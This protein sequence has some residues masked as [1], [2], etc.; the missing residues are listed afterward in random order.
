MTELA[1]YDLAVE[2]TSFYALQH[3]AWLVGHVL[4][5]NGKHVARV[6]LMRL[7]EQ[8]ES[9]LAVTEESLAWLIFDY[10]CLACMGEARHS[11]SASNGYLTSFDWTRNSSR[12]S[13]AA[14]VVGNYDPYEFLPKLIDLFDIPKWESSYGGRKWGELA[15]TALRFLDKQW[16]AAVLIDHCVDL[17]HNG[18]LCFNKGF[19]LDCSF[20]Q[21]QL[22]ALLDDKASKKPLSEWHG[23]TKMG[24]TVLWLIHALQRHGLIKPVRGVPVEWCEICGECHRNFEIPLVCRFL[25]DVPPLEGLVKTL[26]DTGYVPIRWKRISEGAETVG[27]LVVKPSG[28]DEEDENTDG[29]EE[30]LTGSGCNLNDHEPCN[31]GCDTCPYNHGGCSENGYD[32]CDGDCDVCPFNAVTPVVDKEALAENFNNINAITSVSDVKDVTKFSRQGEQE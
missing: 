8:I 13:V 31:D 10:L 26:A 21:S 2:I 5:R 18:G 16:S 30:N 28:E 25:S 27:D 20:E 11:H 17:V 19:L 15:R 3:M 23:C 6:S 12:E 29:E 24:G 4:S 9:N 22:E 32:P 1:R 14:G 7:L